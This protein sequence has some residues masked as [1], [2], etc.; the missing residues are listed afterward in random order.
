MKEFGGDIFQTDSARAP[1]VHSELRGGE[2]GD[3]ANGCKLIA[4]MWID[5]LIPIN[6]GQ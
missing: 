3:A 6:Q 4:V 2:A 5:P 1:N